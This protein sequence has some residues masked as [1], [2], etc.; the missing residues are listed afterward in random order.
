MDR[1]FWIILS[2]SWSRWK[3]ALALVK[4]E[5]VIAWH[6]R[7]FARF[8]TWKSER[9]GRPPIMPELVEL[10]V[11]TSSCSDGAICCDAFA[12]TCGTTISIALTYRSAA[13]PRLV[14]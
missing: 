8:W 2:R 6:R 9:I 7:G 10:I 3:D 14:E 5:T 11:L 4:P 12:T 13:I 1:A